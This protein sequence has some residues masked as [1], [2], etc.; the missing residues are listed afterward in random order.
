MENINNKTFLDYFKSKSE[1]DI[2]IFKNCFEE[3]QNSRQ[4][5]PPKEPFK[6]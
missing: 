6:F 4:K 1:I 3:I 2:S 5:R